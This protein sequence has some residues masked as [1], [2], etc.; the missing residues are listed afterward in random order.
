MGIRVRKG[1]GT[2]S[3][4]ISLCVLSFL[5]SCA[6][7]WPGNPTQDAVTPDIDY[8]ADFSADVPT[9]YYYNSWWVLAGR[10]KCPQVFIYDFNM[11]DTNIDAG[12]CFFCGFSLGYV[13]IDDVS[14]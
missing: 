12:I 7:I 6:S 8:R 10:A 9:L 11:Q 4:S 5:L 1:F 14:I 3:V 13:Y 2:V